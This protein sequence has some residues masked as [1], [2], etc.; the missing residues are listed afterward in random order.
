MLSFK[1][2]ADMGGA[3]AKVSRICSRKDVGTFAATEAARLMQPYVPERTGVLM[4]AR[5]S[6]FIVRYNTP[7]A[8]YQYE[9]RNI[10]HRTKAGSISHWDRGISLI[11]ANKAALANAITA[12]LK[13]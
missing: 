9:G 4:N 13:R 6:P 11:P 2:K 7:Y 3:A 10:R 1:V 5:V 12:Y 8:R